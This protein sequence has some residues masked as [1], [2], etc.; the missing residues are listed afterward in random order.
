MIKA[1]GEVGVVMTA[2]TAVVGGDTTTVVVELVEFIALC[3]GTVGLVIFARKP[4]TVIPDD[5]FNINCVR[6]GC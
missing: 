1:E 2:V 4:V 6:A 5:S 3:G